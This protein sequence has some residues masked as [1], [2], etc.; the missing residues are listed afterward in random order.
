MNHGRS[1]FLIGSKE[2]RLKKWIGKRVEV[3][4]RGEGVLMFF[5]NVQFNKGAKWGGVA[6]DEPN[7][8]SFVSCMHG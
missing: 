2:D 1:L 3:E 7:V 5:G 4:G 8:R 6:L